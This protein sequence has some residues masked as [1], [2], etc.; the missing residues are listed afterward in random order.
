MHFYHISNFGEIIGYLCT[1]LSDDL[2]NSK[3]YLVIISCHWHHLSWVSHGIPKPYQ[4]YSWVI[5]FCQCTVS[6]CAYLAKSYTELCI[7]LLLNLWHLGTPIAEN[8]ICYV[9]QTG[10]SYAAYTV[11][12]NFENKSLSV[13]C[14]T[15]AHRWRLSQVLHIWWLCKFSN[16]LRTADITSKS[17]M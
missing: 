11:I 9:K 1:F 8:K 14:F 15:S 2:Q 12:T 5:A 4:H 3:N 13:P 7:H 10:A 6:L 16:L 17:I